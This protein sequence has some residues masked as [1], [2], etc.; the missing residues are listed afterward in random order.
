MSARLPGWLSGRV[1]G[2]LESAAARAIATVDARRDAALARPVHSDRTAAILGISLGITFGLC[3]LTG[4]YSYLL[5]NPLGWLTFPPRPTGLYRITQGLHVVSG[6]A[7]VPLLLAKLWAVYPRLFRRPLV[8]NLPHALERLMLVPLVCGAVFML[9]SGVA[10]VARWYPWGFYFPTAHFWVA[11][12]TI[13]ALVA[14]LGAKATI[15]RQALRRGMSGISPGGL[16]APTRTSSGEPQERTPALG[17]RGFLAAVA[18][19]VG[20]VTVTTAGQTFPPLRPFTLFAQRRPDIGPQG[21]PVNKSATEAGVIEAAQSSSY[22]L[23]VTGTVTEE[24][25]FTADDLDARATHEADLPIACV[26]GWSASAHW[27]GIPVKDLLDAAGTETDGE[28]SVEV[29]SLQEGGRYRTSTL[30]HLQALD[31]DTMLAVAVNGERLDLDHGF[32]CRLISPN[33]PGVLQ[34]KWVTEL[35]VIR[36]V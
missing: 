35:V 7:S 10:N 5:Q 30:N 36:G 8:V 28:F 3:F 13:G 19:A 15:A 16:P 24:L 4:L 11:W 22:R 29:R 32:P 31:P 33:R 25:S 6:L 18:G 12:I 1:P 21:L 20:L 26:E 34:T 23:T 2:Q 14:H 17:R 27:R 9:F